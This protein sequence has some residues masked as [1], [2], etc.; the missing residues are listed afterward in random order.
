[1]TDSNGLALPVGG[2]LH[3]VSPCA[4][5]MRIA[6][7]RRLK[8][9]SLLFGEGTC[10][11][12][13]GCALE[14]RLR[15]EKVPNM[16]SLYLRGFPNYKKQ[17]SARITRESGSEPDSKQVPVPT[18]ICTGSTK[19]AGCKCTC[20]ERRISKTNVVLVCGNVYRE[21]TVHMD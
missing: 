9:H 11:V 5:T 4:H 17:P 15:T 12:W 21:S 19:K 7:T 16:A 1:M 2:F 13:H 8:T 10:L 6:C 14:S 3:G 18:F 20:T